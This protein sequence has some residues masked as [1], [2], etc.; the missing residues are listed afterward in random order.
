MLLKY[1][2]I[3]WRHIVKNGI[4]SV[5]NITGLSLAI[6]ITALIMLWVMDEFGYDRFHPQMDRIYS[7]YGH[8]SYSD[9]QEL[10]TRSTPFPLAEELMSSQPGIEIATT[11][12]D[13]GDRIVS[14]DGK[15]S[16][17]GPVYC[18]DANFLKIFNFDI[19][20]GDPRVLETAD[21]AIVTK[22]LAISL[23]G[24]QSA[25]GKT[26][27]IDNGKPVVIGA[28]IQ[29]PPLRSTVNFKALIPIKYMETWGADLSAWN[30]NWPY[31]SV[32]LEKNADA[33][34]IDKQ[35]TDICKKHEQPN[36]SLHLFRFA[37]SHLYSLSGKNNRVQYVYLFVVI[38][39]VILLIASFNF[40]N[41]SISRTEHRH[42]E[43]GVRKA[44]GAAKHHI[45]Q[46]FL[47]ENGI[48]VLASLLTG[49][50]LAT[51]LMPV[52]NSLADKQLEISHLFSVAVALSLSAIVLVIL[53]LSAAYPSVRIAS[54][55][56]VLALKKAG[57]RHTNTKRRS[58]LVISQFIM[59]V[60][61]ISSSI[62]ISK[63]IKYVYNFDLGYNHANLVYL[64]LEGRAR[65]MHAAMKQEL[66]GI[67]GI[68]ALTCTNTLP[69]GSSQSSWGFDWEGKDPDLKL[70]MRQ[71]R[72]DNH[73]FE[74]M[75]IEIIEGQTFSD[76]YDNR[77]VIAPQVL[78][79]QKAVQR[80]GIKAPVGKYFVTGN[81]QKSTI[82]GVVADF[83]FESL[84][85][86]VE[87]LLIAP[88]TEMP[89]YIIIRLNPSFFP[90]TVDDIKKTWAKVAPASACQLGFFDDRI[91]K[92][93]NSE[94][95]ISALFRGFSL[96]AIFIAG[97]GL[98]GLSLFI[99]DKRKKEIGIRKVNGSTVAEI[100][101]LLNRDFVKW[102]AI[103]FVLATPVAWYAM[104]RWLQNFA[105]RTELNWWIFALSGLMALIVALLTVSWQSW[106]AATRNPIEAL[107]YE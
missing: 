78:L 103:A 54:L 51:A 4:F 60:A 100:L 58:L 84:H 102:V 48:M 80:M 7:V 55:N 96:V 39:F 13:L 42:R 94:S 19:L 61:L 6:A 56:A 83:N 88:L 17:A 77:Q 10:H 59:S 30:S 45:L 91:E 9:G 86:E 72:A 76:L 47:L 93:Y 82:A 105:Y 107:R 18:V 16:K 73:Y 74:T 15:E 38:A 79:N 87:P 1:I 31:T 67:P 95:K 21:G 81:G 35:I 69:L 29:S 85:N 34:L 27:T 46:Q 65:E 28:I 2:T 40:I 97:I 68:K 50:V 25:V 104:H 37:D 36:T 49:S 101:A 57:G 24:T 33:Q 20:E 44:L 14:F 66:S 71:M 53:G 8:Q 32:L 63:Q 52:F 64:P 23:F 41:L 106:K 89:R 43:I 12:S 62:V 26:L 22:E 5:I 75:G 92:L 11:Y 98:F 90:Q 99:I 3:G 70:L